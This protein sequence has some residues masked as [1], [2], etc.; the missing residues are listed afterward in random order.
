MKRSP[1]PTVPVSELQA[2]LG[3]WLRFVSN[4]VSHAFAQK[5]A[6][7]G[8]TVAESVLL[9]EMLRTGPANPSD[10]ADNLGLSRGAISK[11]IDRLTTKKLAKRCAAQS[12]DRRYQTVSLTAKGTK[13]VPTLAAL[14]DQN[15]REFFG[16][17]TA[18]EQS[19]MI[20]LLYDI[21]RRHEWKD[22]SVS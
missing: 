9:R 18:A 4:H 2:H 3:Y 21:A 1:S 15:D 17:L 10:L 20:K 8:V 5:V 19:D 6:G 14:A 12:A 11:L 22:V 16:H 13:L 7:Q